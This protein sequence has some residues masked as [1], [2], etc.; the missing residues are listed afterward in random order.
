MAAGTVRGENPAEAAGAVRGIQPDGQGCFLSVK[1][2]AE[3]YGHAGGHKKRP[4]GCDPRGGSGVLLH[5]RPSGAWMLSAS[6]EDMGERLLSEI[7]REEK[8]LLFLVHQDF[9]R[10]SIARR[11]HR[12]LVNECIQAV[13]TRKRPPACAA[14]FRVRPL[15]PQ[16]VDAVYESY[17]AVHSRTYLLERIE[18]GE[19]FGI[20]ENG[21]L[22]AFAGTHAEGSMGMLEVLPD[23]RRRGMGE[24]LE[25]CLIARQL[26]KGWV[27]FCQIFDGNEPSLR[28]QKKLI[29]STAKI[30]VYINSFRCSTTIL[31]FELI[32]I[33][34]IHVVYTVYSRG[35]RFMTGFLRTMLQF[36]RPPEPARCRAC[37]NRWL[38]LSGRRERRFMSKGSCEAAESAERGFANG[39]E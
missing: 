4:G 39:A 28:L 22:A 17:H 8:E 33:S 3:P 34:P 16:D 11:F 32:S 21:R 23:H 20:D 24:A 12:N 31:V 25:A 18:A 38:V 15:V 37:T 6:D 26:E 29:P 35:G 36:T 10:D 27:P 7:P 19:M 2:P 5:D 30:P 1:G 14:D 13:Y 9:L